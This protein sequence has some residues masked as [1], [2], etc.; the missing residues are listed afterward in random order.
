MMAHPG[1]YPPGQVCYPPELPAYLKNV[2]DLKPIAGVPGDDE[3]IGIHAVVQA[4]RKA[5]EIPGMN[6]PI[7]TMKLTDHLF[8]AQMARYRNKYS[9]ITFPSHATYTPP[10]LSPNLSVDLRPISGTPSDEELIKVQDAV[11]TYQEFRRFPSMFDPRVNME[12]SQH[13]FDLQMA[14]YMRL[15]GESLQSSAQRSNPEGEKPTRIIVKSLT[16]VD[17][18]TIPTNNAGT[19]A[20]I[21][22]GYQV[23]PLDHGPTMHDLMERSNQLA[24]KFNQLL[25]HSNELAERHSQAV[26]QPIAHTLAERFNTV[27]ERLTQLVEHSQPTR[28]SEERFNELFTRFNQLVEQSH[29]PT[30][31]NNELIEQ[32]NQSSKR[33]HDLSE[34]ANKSWERMGDLLENINKVLMGIQNSIIRSHKS[35]TALRAADCLVNKKGDTPGRSRE[36]SHASFKWLSGKFSKQSG[37]ELPVLIAGTEHILH[38]DDAWL[39]IFLRFYDIGAH[40][41]EGKTTTKFKEEHAKSARLL[42]GNYLSSCLG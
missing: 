24:E 21:S 2:Y 31:R 26:D 9:L 18:A 28:Q 39:G 3:V 30:E 10:I 7:L 20:R 13:L 16:A 27:I 41:F 6:D 32:L 14:R 1:W 29:Q 25:E 33:S 15:A 23:P 19:G 34:Q 4:A 5:S 17:E 37:C 8:N 12:L 36:A 40:Y 42:L 22:E 11:Q 38:I 35:N